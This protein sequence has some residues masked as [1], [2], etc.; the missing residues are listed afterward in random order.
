M[1]I[2]DLFVTVTL[3]GLLATAAAP[4]FWGHLERPHADDD[5]SPTSDSA[6]V[7]IANDD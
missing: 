4:A 6:P 5:H 1:T 2:C 7:G 3:L